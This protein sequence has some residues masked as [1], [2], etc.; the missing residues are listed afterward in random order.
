MS[1]FAP[2]SDIVQPDTTEE[3]KG[4]W[5][6]GTVRTV[7]PDGSETVKAHVPGLFDM[8]AGDVPWIGPLKQSLFG[9][10]PNFGFYGAPQVGSRI[11]I[12]LQDGD[13]QYPAYIGCILNKQDIPPQFKDPNVW[14][15]RDPAGNQLLVNIKTGEFR[16]THSSGAYFSFDSGGNIVLKGKTIQLNPPG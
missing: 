9:I 7:N 2:L 14:G 1:G 3:S 16:F 12:I 15:F 6:I 5:Y 8:D 11:T 4:K 10:G 13:A